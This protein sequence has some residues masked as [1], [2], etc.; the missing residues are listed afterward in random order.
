LNELSFDLERL[1][2]LIHSRIRLAV[3]AILYRGEC[4]GFGELRD[5]L[6]L[7][8]GNLG[9]NLKKLEEEGLIS[10]RHGGKGNP[11]FAITEKGKKRFGNYLEALV[12]LL[13]R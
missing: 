6:S 3:L 2:P 13:E 7:T 11:G 5:A 9:S 8:D 1:D 12:E 4:P 10:S